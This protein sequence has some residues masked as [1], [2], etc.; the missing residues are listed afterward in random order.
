MMFKGVLERLGV[1]RRANRDRRRSLVRRR[2][3]EGLEQR[4]NFSAVSIVGGE[5]RY[6]GSAAANVV[7]IDY[8]SVTDEYTFTDSEPING[9][10]LPIG[11]PYTFT[12][13][14][15][16]VTSRLLVDPGNGGGDIITI[17]GM[18][19]NSEGLS[20]VNRSGS[21]TV[22]INGDLTNVGGFVQL[23]ADNITLN[24]DISTVNQAVQ[25][26]GAVDVGADSVVS[27]G[28]GT[29]SFLNTLD[30]VT[31]SDLTLNARNVTANVQ[32][33]GGT[34]GLGQFTVNATLNATF[35]TSSV[36][37][38]IAAEAINVSAGG[39][40]TFSGDLTSGAGGI[41]VI[42]PTATIIRDGARS[43]TSLDA[44]I[45]FTGTL[46]TGDG[47][48]V[49]PVI[50]AGN[51]DLV[52]GTD[53]NFSGRPVD[54]TASTVDV[55]MAIVGSSVL[56]NAVD[57]VSA[58]TIQSTVG[59]VSIAV[60][61]GALDF[62]S[63][64]EAFASV[65]SAADV[66]IDALNV[67]ASGAAKSLTI[68]APG[69]ITISGDVSN[70]T[71]VRIGAE[72]GGASNSITL[73]DG[74]VVGGSLNLEATT[75]FLADSL[76][77]GAGVLIEGQTELTGPIV[78][79][80]T[81]SA[82]DRIQFTGDVNPSVAGTSLT[83]NAGEGTIQ[84]LG[85]AQLG[86][87][88]RLGDVVLSA[89]DI[90][91]NQLFADNVRFEG[92]TLGLAQTVDGTGEAVF[93]PR[94]PGEGVFL[95]STPANPSGSGI[96]INTTTLSQL[97]GFN[98]VGFGDGAT[99]NVEIVNDFV[100]STSLALGVDAVF[101]GQTINL[102]ETL[103]LGTGLNATDVTFATT[104]LNVNNGLTFVGTGAVTISP[105]APAGAAT[106]NGRLVG[107]GSSLPDVVLDTT[108]G[109]I[110]VVNEFGNF[111]SI[112]VINGGAVSFSD[113]VT[114]VTS[115][116]AF[117]SNA[118]TTNVAGGIHASGPITVGG[119]LNLISNTLLFSR[120]GGDIVT[121]D[122]VGNGFAL[123]ARGTSANPAPLIEFGGNVTG[124]SMM[125]INLVTNVV[126]GG[127]VT[128]TTVGGDLN[129][130]ANGNLS[131]GGD[132]IAND[133]IGLIFA[134]AD[135]AGGDRLIDSVTDTQVIITGALTGMGV[136]TVDVLP[137]QLLRSGSN[138]TV[139]VNLV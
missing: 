98:L 15:A 132:L 78:I 85:G 38:S 56:I 41:S 11:G 82:L 50:D 119:T 86:N 111:A 34:D 40:A 66:D 4:I 120:G 87:N 123:R 136:L 77:A 96:R 52:V 129:V 72:A 84:M 106:V 3:F 118:T 47:V 110:E 80:S 44:D 35:G 69:D 130:K 25:F 33:I 91:I 42:A 27:A 21:Q 139:T 29:I 54:V 137:G 83:L 46:R 90:A 13:S 92:G 32:P 19:A 5:L 93:V 20:T 62:D 95:F 1:S 37:V 133:R 17:N 104:T 131:L 125:D 97:Q 39:T 18:A 16:G 53:L 124:L 116:G 60:L 64:T 138:G 36:D 107:R 128:V 48:A 24:A 81:G 58:T 114:A 43:I 122:I 76:T 101:T 102:G 74:A 75:I 71:S 108:G 73:N 7:T 31:T 6:V 126:F 117:T 49:N 121:G 10:N 100:R 134:T 12:I 88:A 63:G 57:G 2:I 79:T 51:G 113:P 68:E 28:N 109:S 94:V 59:N 45:S 67:V 115:L 26:D 103:N 23:R 61:N 70:F 135:L 127:N 14:G 105:I 8:N 22:I 9:N 112:A 65:R 99:A 89:N 55:G 30:S